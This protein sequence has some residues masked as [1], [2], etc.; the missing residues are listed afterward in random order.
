MN[1]METLDL[2]TRDQIDVLTDRVAS[3]ERQLR[4]LVEREDGARVLALRMDQRLKNHEA[5]LLTL[6]RPRR[7]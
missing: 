3:L 1:G 5:R 4:D 6:E 2:V 7:R